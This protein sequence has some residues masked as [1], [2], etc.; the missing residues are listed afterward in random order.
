MTLK[1]LVEKFSNYDFC[2][3]V[4]VNDDEYLLGIINQSLE[5]NKAFYVSDGSEPG[6]IVLIVE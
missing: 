3:I 1:E 5:I 6:K 2:E 4:A